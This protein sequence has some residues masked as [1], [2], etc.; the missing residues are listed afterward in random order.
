MVLG[1]GLFVFLFNL[2]GFVGLLLMPP[3]VGIVWGGLLGTLFLVW[4]LRN[5]EGRRKRFALLRLRPPRA[6]RGWQLLAVGASLALLW[7]L[8]G[9][10]GWAGPPLDPD[11][12]RNWEPLSRYLQKPGGWLAGAVLT[13]FA[14][15]VVEE[16]A[17]RGYIQHTLERRWG[18]VPAI[19][20]ATL[21]FTIAHLGRPHW[22]LLLIPLTL[23]LTN[24]MVTWLARSIWPAVIIHASW[25]LL[26]TVGA[27]L[28]EPVDAT[29]P[30]SPWLWLAWSA[31][32]LVLG[33]AGWV[34]LLRGGRPAARGRPPS[35]GEQAVQRDP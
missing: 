10:I 32:A 1:A 8:A 28:P 15:P 9:V 31:L 30:A 18:V 27:I 16:M 7:G 22:S 21:L 4:Q 3:S 19:G 26:M 2:V 34:R 17:F 35:F 11:A 25:N 24:G 23:G 5:D 6:S 14:V 29:G 13:A 12:L 33:V 20:V